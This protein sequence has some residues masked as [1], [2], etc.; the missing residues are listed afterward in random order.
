MGKQVLKHSLRSPVQESPPPPKASSLPEP[1]RSVISINGPIR[2]ADT[3]NNTIAIDLSALCAFLLHN[4]HLFPNMSIWDF[5]RY[6]QTCGFR[7]LTSTSSNSLLYRHILLEKNQAKP[8]RH[9]Q[10]NV[11]VD[12]NKQALADARDSTSLLKKHRQ[13]TDK[14]RMIANRS[15]V[16]S[17]KWATALKMLHLERE[18]S[19]SRAVIPL[20]YFKNPAYSQSNLMQ[21]DYAGFYGNLAVD[22][23]EMCFG[24][25]LPM[26]STEAIST[27]YQRADDCTMVSDDARH[28]TQSPV[29]GELMDT[30][31]A[32]E[33]YSTVSSV[34]IE[35]EIDMK[36]RMPDMPLLYI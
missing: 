1:L 17:N 2:W 33:V 25:F 3:K 23:V 7:S 19:Q 29:S 14:C 32:L 36:I 21:S 22:A 16:A 26:Y 9:K 10:F 31:P 8:Q 18:I 12:D 5:L 15:A 24:A 11:T 34:E 13:L 20:E 4:E 27:I 30:G 35:D 6:L 28:P